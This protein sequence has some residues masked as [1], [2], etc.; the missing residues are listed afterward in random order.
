MNY[1]NNEEANQKITADLQT[2]DTKVPTHPD[3]METLNRIYTEYDEA[4]RILAEY[5]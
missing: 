5:D 2:Q 1:T 3:L 4:F